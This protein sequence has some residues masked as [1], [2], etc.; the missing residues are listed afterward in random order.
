MTTFW[1]LAFCEAT[2]EDIDMYLADGWEPFATFSV[3]VS[4]LLFRKPAIKKEDARVVERKEITG[5]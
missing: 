2:K 3:G 5:D 1:Q 4:R